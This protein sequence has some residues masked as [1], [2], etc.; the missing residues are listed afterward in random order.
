MPGTD[1][2]QYTMFAT[3]TANRIDRKNLP[4]GV[5]RFYKDEREV[6]SFR[7]HVSGWKE[8]RKDGG[9][10]IVDG[11]NAESEASG[12]FRVFQQET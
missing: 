6:S 1:F 8:W 4:V 3:G 2:L 5:L 10:R 9:D 11:R 12:G 7:F